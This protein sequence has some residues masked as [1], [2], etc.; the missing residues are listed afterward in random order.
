MAAEGGGFEWLVFVL[1]LSV[2]SALMAAMWIFLTSP[3]RSP[4]QVF[5][6]PSFFNK[7]VVV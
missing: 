1:V 4:G 7:T 6:F 2:S 3:S 5:C